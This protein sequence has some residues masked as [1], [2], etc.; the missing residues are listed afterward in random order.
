MTYTDEKIIEFEYDTQADALA[1]MQ[2]GGEVYPMLEE[3]YTDAEGRQLS[4]QE[5]A[6]LVELG[7]WII[8][9]IL[10]IPIP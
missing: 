10:G 1:A 8:R 4:K 2:E 7:K 3:G 5:M 9:L 6:F